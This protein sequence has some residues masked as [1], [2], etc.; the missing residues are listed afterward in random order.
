MSA[1]EQEPH[2]QRWLSQLEAYRVATG[3]SPTAPVIPTASSEPKISL[4]IHPETQSDFK[5]PATT[6]AIPAVESVQQS[7]SSHHAPSQIVH[8]PIDG[9]LNRLKKAKRFV[10]GIG[11]VGAVDGSVV[12]NLVT[13]IVDRCCDKTQRK[14]IL[15][16]IRPTEDG[17]PKVL[18]EKASFTEAQWSYM[19]NSKPE[20]KLWHSQLAQ[21]PL[22][23]KEFGLI[24]F[25]LGDVCLPMMPRV[26]RLCDG[27]VVQMLN[28]SNTRESIQA[29]RSLQKER[30]PILGAWSVDFS[31]RELAA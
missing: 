31:M 18:R 26:G 17:R 15:V 1:Q 27:I 22:W 28:P 5:K 13:D 30:L 24:V 21:L 23:K 25:D 16:T 10:L 11:T 4:R 8:L 29:I 14:A 20:T 3:K 12:R 19:G 2:L 6:E 9:I 7:V